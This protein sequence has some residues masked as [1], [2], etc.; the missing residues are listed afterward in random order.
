MKKEILI[1]VIIEDNKFGSIIQKN[2]FNESLSSQKEMVSWLYH[3]AKDEDDKLRKKME[4]TVNYTV[5]EPYT[6]N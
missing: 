6:N 3:I 1:R 5:K 2:G 4:M